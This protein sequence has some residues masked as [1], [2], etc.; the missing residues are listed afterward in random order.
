ML[1][2]YVRIKMLVA[3]KEVSTLLYSLQYYYIIYSNQAME[4]I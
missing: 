1:F 3:I 2:Y 4:R